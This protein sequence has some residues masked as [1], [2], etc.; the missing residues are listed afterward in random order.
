MMNRYLSGCHP[1]RAQ[2][3]PRLF[4]LRAILFM[5]FSFFFEV[6]FLAT[7]AT[8]KLLALLLHFDHLLI[9]EDGSAMSKRLRPVP[10]LLF[11]A[12]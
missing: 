7:K 11:E 6:K 3:C 4:T 9:D 12:V 10:G 1:A 8:F 2:L 5:L